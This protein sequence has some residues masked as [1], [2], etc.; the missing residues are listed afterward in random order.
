[1]GAQVTQSA[2]PGSLLEKA[3]RGGH[4]RRHGPFLQVAGVEMVELAQ[5][6][7]LDE[8]VGQHHGWEP[9]VVELHGIHHARLAHRRQHGL[10]LGQRIG[11]CFFAQHVL[12]GL[13]GSDGDG[14]V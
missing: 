3:P 5:A 14:G 11:Q 10:S 6:A 7:F 1:M 12:A 13:G 9:A 4:L 2:G 8:L